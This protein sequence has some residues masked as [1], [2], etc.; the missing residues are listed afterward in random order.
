MSIMKADRVAKP[1][2]THGG[3]RCSASPS[4]RIWQG[5]L[6]E[7]NAIAGRLMDG[8]QFGMPLHECELWANNRWNVISIDLGRRLPP[9]RRMRCPECHGRVRFHKEGKNGETAH[10]EH[11]ERNAGCSKGDCFDGTPRRHRRPLT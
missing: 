11:S 2:T 9:E 7:N 3:G 6:F 8:A 1:L 10:F 4:L 5:E